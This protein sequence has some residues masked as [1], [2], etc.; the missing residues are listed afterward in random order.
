FGAFDDRGSDILDVSLLYD[1]RGGD[2]APTGYAGCNGDGNGPSYRWIE[3]PRITIEAGDLDPTDHR[4]PP[5]IPA[6]DQDFGPSQTP[7][8]SPL[9][10]WRVFLGRVTRDRSDPSKPPTYAVD[11]AGRPYVDLVGEYIKAASGKAAVQIGEFSQA[12][13]GGASTEPGAPAAT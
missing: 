6:A 4:H 13:T 11:M 7:P 2:V 10:E 1:L 3:T 12:V 8:D 9:R 5:G